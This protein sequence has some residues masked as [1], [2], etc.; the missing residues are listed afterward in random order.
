MEIDENTFNH[1]M[2]MSRNATVGFAHSYITRLI[3]HFGF[4]AEEPK[5]GIISAFFKIPNLPTAPVNLLFVP[6]PGQG[7]EYAEAAGLA[8]PVTGI[9]QGACPAVID[10]TSPASAAVSVE[11][12]VNKPRNTTEF[13]PTDKII[14]EFLNQQFS[15]FVLLQAGIPRQEI[16]LCSQEEIMERRK[17]RIQVSRNTLHGYTGPMAHEKPMTAFLKK[18]VAPMHTK[19]ATA[20]R[21]VS[22]LNAEA[23]LRTGT[24]GLALAEVMR[25][26]GFST[27]RN[28]PLEMGEAMGEVANEAKGVEHLGEVVDPGVGVTP[29][30]PQATIGHASVGAVKPPPPHILFAMLAQRRTALPELSAFDSNADREMFAALQI[31]QRCDLGQSPTK[32]EIEF[33]EMVAKREKLVMNDLY[34]IAAKDFSKMDAS[35]S[36]DL[37]GLYEWFCSEVI[38]PED[39]EHLEWIQ[40]A[41]TNK[42]VNCGPVKFCTGTMNT[43]GV[44]DTTEMNTYLNGV[45]NFI[46]CYYCLLL[47]DF[48]SKQCKIPQSM[49]NDASLAEPRTQ[50]WEDEVCR[51]MKVLRKFLNNHGVSRHKWKSMC[52]CRSDT[53][54]VVKYLQRQGGW[55]EMQ[56][57]LVEEAFQEQGKAFGDDSLCQFP[58]GVTS[59][60]HEAAMRVYCEQTGWKMTCDY[61]KS[62]EPVSFC[63]RTYPLAGSSPVSHSDV[64]KSCLRISVVKVSG[65][66]KMAALQNTIRGYLT[67]DSKTPLLS[68]YCRALARVF[69]LNSDQLTDEEISELFDVDRDMYYKCKKDPYPATPDEVMM[70]HESVA[71]SL[72]I[73]PWQLT[74]LCEALDKAM[75]EEDIFLLQIDVGLPEQNDPPN[76]VRVQSM[77]DQQLNW[78]AAEDNWKVKVTQFLDAHP[79]LAVPDP[80]LSLSDS[81]S[82]AAPGSETPTL[83][84]EAGGEFTSVTSDVDSEP[85]KVSADGHDNNDGPT[86]DGGG[87]SSPSSSPSVSETRTSSKKDKPAKGTRGTSGGKKD[88]KQGRSNSAESVNV[89]SETSRA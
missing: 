32:D 76:T 19:P 5:I 10:C 63:G 39:H 61:H 84:S 8:S 81:A 57:S 35:I 24:L 13:N 23:A 38:H 4:H 46:I 62:G 50:S 75:T 47:R 41:C 86:Q 51:L 88:G 6:E 40:T 77:F 60:M 29:P 65:D 67:C 58:R 17:G 16:R 71:K 85:T 66:G 64:I 21:I 73:D 59:M 42:E 43:S 12:R 31:I 49:L 89:R 7:P 37:R 36:R 83:G 33:I 20:A 28:N 79:G 44:G 70:I 25:L 2:S 78:S 11:A 87:S 52:K 18:E 72:K 69:K 45:S 48:C 1:L 3:K 80:S 9:F 74:S 15:R 22:N 53:E 14:L 27:V 68:N 55:S 54:A 34:V 82:Q 30:I 26:V 56:V